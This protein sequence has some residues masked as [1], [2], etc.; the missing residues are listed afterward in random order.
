MGA[1]PADSAPPP[2]AEGEAP[3]LYTDEAG[4]SELPAYEAT[5]SASTDNGD[6]DVPPPAEKTKAK[7]ALLSEKE[8]LSS[9]PPSFTPAKTTAGPSRSML[10]IG[11]DADDVNDG[12]FRSTDILPPAVLVLDGTAIYSATDATKAPVYTLELDFLAHPNV[13]PKFPTRRLLGIEFYRMEPDPKAPDSSSRQKANRI[14]NLNQRIDIVGVGF[15]TVFS[16]EPAGGPSRKLGTWGLKAPASVAGVNYGSSWKVLPVDVHR[17]TNYYTSLF[18]ETAPPLWTVKRVQDQVY[19][20]VAGP[21]PPPPRLK[22]QTPFSSQLLDSRHQKHKL[23][24]H[25]LGNLNEAVLPEGADVAMDYGRSKDS[26]DGELPRL[27]IT[28]SMTRQ[29]RDA[30]VALWCLRQWSMILF[31]GATPPPLSTLPVLPTSTTNDSSILQAPLFPNPFLSRLGKKVK[32][33]G[34]AK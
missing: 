25:Q 11:D 23:D 6:Q 16:I 34:K 32:G 15:G 5:A 20:W 18:V 9:P 3:P 8:K 33:K 7:E 28:A 13:N 22:Q 12:R 4:P 26:K 29:K 14:Y 17:G 19:K 27:V 30:L 24:S 1:P 21:P 2:E 31:G 10:D